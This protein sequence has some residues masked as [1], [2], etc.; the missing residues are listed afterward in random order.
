MEQKTSYYLEQLALD[1]VVKEYIARGYKVQTEVKVNNNLRVDAIATKMGETIII[2]V[3]SGKVSKNTIAA[4][5]EIKKY[6]T[7][8]PNTRFK[9][10]VATPPKDKVLEVDW[11]ATALEEHI[12]NNPTNDLDTL[13]TH[14]R[15]IEVC[16]I[17]IDEFIWNEELITAS[18]TGMVTVSLQYGSN[19]DQEAGYK[20]TAETFSFKFDAVFNEEKNIEEL[21]EFQVDTTEFYEEGDG[22]N[23]IFY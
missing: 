21:N 6:A 10:V 16:D 22:S 23:K 15:I 20:D 8:Q 12:T 4:M 9:L 11:I 3:K 2:E 18:G 7:T 19:S 17:E 1:Q 14:T 5:K 13:S